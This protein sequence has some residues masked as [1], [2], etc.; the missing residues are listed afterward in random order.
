MAKLGGWEYNIEKDQLV[1]TDEVYR[2][3]ELPLRERVNIEEALTYYPGKAREKIEDA[4][5]Y[6]METGKQYDLSVPFITLNDNKKWVRAIGQAHFVDGKPYKL[7]GT[8]QDITQQKEYEQ[9]IKDQNQSL[10]K[11]TSTR[12]KLFSIIGHDLKN[13]FFGSLGLIDIMKEEKD[14]ENYSE[15]EFLQQLDLLQSTMNNAYELLENLLDWIRMQREEVIPDFKK[16]HVDELIE[17]SILVYKAVAKNKSISFEMDIDS[18]PPITADAEV[19]K[20]CFRNLIS[21]ALKFSQKNSTIWVS[22]SEKEK[23]VIITV[24]DSGIGMPR[25]VKN[26]LF[27]PTHRPKR[28]GTQSERGTGLG[29]LLCKEF[30]ELHNGTIEV[31]SEVEKGSEFI[32]TLPKSHKKSQA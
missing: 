4:L 14:S 16:V 8:F 18:V 27:D 13:T 30:V 15:E 10:K 2:I 20:T 7:R 9:R 32:V 6:T 11:L 19:L 17:Q 26:S 28:Q 29:L 21:N 3:H 25:E 24:K 1:W 31:I 12:D 5:D 23:N 22:A